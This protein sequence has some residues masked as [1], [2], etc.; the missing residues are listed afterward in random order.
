MITQESDAFCREHWQGDHERFFSAMADRRWFAA[1]WPVAL[2]GTGWTRQQQLDFAGTLA[3]HRCPMPPESVTLAAPLLIEKNDI[4]DRSDLLTAISAQPLNWLPHYDSEN[5]ALY[6][7]NNNLRVTLALPGT[8]DR[9]LA[10]CFSPL[11]QLYEWMLGLSHVNEI[12]ACRGEPV[13]DA[14]TEMRVQLDAVTA[15]F[16]KGST[17]ADRQ[18]NLETARSRLPVFGALFQAIGYY[19]LLDPDPQLSSN[20]PIPFREERHHLDQLRRLMTRNEILQM[21]LLY[22]EISGETFGDE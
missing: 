2:G 11:W 7:S 15:L 5:D 3:R 4:H 10:Q 12:T 1:D 14:I 20:E 8:A 17:L 9:W 22:Q 6:L 19:A 18:L 21:D 16:L 13:T